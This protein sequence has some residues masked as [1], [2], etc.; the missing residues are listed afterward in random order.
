MAKD[1]LSLDDKVQLLEFEHRKL[2]KD[3]SYMERKSS[4]LDY[5]KIKDMKKRKLE[6]KDRIVSLRSN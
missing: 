1:D 4:V 5:M 3:I 6:L 2:D